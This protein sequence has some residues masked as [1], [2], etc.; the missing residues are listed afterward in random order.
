MEQVVKDL[1]RRN[2][3]GY[4]LCRFIEL[5]RSVDRFVKK[6]IKIKIAQTRQVNTP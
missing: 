1:N 4:E 5:F 6:I 3:L 2:L